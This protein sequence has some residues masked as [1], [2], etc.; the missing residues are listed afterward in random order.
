MKIHLKSGMIMPTKILTTQK[1]P[2]QGL[3]WWHHHQGQWPH[4]LDLC[5]VLCGQMYNVQMQMWN[6]PPSCNGFHQTSM[7]SGWFN[8]SPPF[9]RSFLASTRGQRYS[10]RWMRFKGTTRSLWMMIAAFSPPSSCLGVASGTTEP[11]W[12]S[13]PLLTNGQLDKAIKGIPRVWKLV[14]N[15]LVEGETIG[16]LLLHIHQVLDN[17]HYLGITISKQKLEIAS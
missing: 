17:C 11:E 9:R 16:K 14:D 8:L 5:G 1:V 6:Q 15:F 3:G 12:A 10:A 4:C 7:Y 2:L 13:Q